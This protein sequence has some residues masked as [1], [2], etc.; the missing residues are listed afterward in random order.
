MPWKHFPDLK[1]QFRVHMLIKRNFE[2]VK[3]FALVIQVM[4]FR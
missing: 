2:K 4:I 1:K 3:K